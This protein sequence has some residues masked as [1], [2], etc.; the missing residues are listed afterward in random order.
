[1][2]ED[3]VRENVIGTGPY[4]VEEYAYDATLQLKAVQDHH[5]KTPNVENIIYEPIVE[6]AVAEAALRTGS[7]DIAAV[8]LRNYPTLTEEGFDIIGAGA[9]FVPLDLVS[10]ETTGRT[11]STRRI[12]M[13]RKCRSRC[14]RRF[15]TTF[16]GSAIRVAT[17]LATRGRFHQHDACCSRAPSAVL[18]NRP[19]SHRRSAFSE[20]A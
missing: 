6:D 16:R 7:I 8:D 2:G 5:R 19:R 10:P 15:N 4:M 13:T 9:G 14:T 12:Q 20:R 17:A 11:R 18:R 3:W 1:M